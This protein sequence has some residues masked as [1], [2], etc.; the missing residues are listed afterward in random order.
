MSFSD[1]VSITI[2]TDTYS[3]PRTSSGKDN[4]EYRNHDDASDVDVKLTASH[5]YGKRTRRVLRVD[6]QK[7]FPVPGSAE[8]IRASA[9]VY[10]VFDLPAMGYTKAEAKDIY[11]GL[12]A[13]ASASSD[14][15]ITKLLGGE[16]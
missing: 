7:L 2:G 4:S 14:A 1:P 8:S 15:L 11:S 5:A 16:S 13:T 3:L 12:K 10:L 9:S 6:H